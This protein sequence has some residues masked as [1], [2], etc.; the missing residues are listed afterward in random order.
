IVDA[1]NGKQNV[2]QGKYEELVSDEYIKMTIGMP[3]LSDSQDVI[4]VEFE[5]R[6][7]GGTQMFFYYQSIVEK[8]RRLTALEYKHQKKE[9]HDSTAHGLELM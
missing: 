8:E 5:E 7:S 6:E 1:R 3:E 2:I 9:Y 4:E